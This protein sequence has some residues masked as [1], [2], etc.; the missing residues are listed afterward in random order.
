MVDSVEREGG[1]RIEREVVRMR[2]RAMIRPSRSN[3]YLYLYLY[4]HES[5]WVEKVLI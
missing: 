4:L 5:F 3:R 1:K 2:E